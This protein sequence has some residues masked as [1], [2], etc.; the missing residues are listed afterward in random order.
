[1]A[2]HC[3]GES[4]SGKAAMILSITRAFLR[5]CCSCRFSHVERP[6]PGGHVFAHDE[7]GAS[8]GG[9]YS[10][11]GP[12]SCPPGGAAPDAVVMQAEKSP[13]RETGRVSGFNPDLARSDRAIVPKKSFGH[14]DLSPD[15]PRRAHGRVCGTRTHK[16]ALP[17]APDRCAPPAPSMGRCDPARTFPGYFYS[18]VMACSVNYRVRTRNCLKTSASPLWEPPP[19]KLPV[20][21]IPALAL[22]ASGRCEPNRQSLPFFLSLPPCGCWKVFLPAQRLP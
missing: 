7:S 4:S 11:H 2:C 12:L 5:S 3:G 6:C 16:C 9:R 13:C 17:T 21:T 1:M 14:G 19:L 8:G 20:T 15:P 18:L 22:C 10:G